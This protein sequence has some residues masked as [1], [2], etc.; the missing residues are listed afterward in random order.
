MHR[1]TGRVALAGVDLEIAP[2]ELFGLL[3]PN[4]GGKTTL[5]R[6]LTTSLSVQEGRAQVFGHDV[7]ASPHA[8]RREMGVVFQSP[9]L[10]KKLS[11]A[12]NLRYH[13]R[14]Y[15]MAGAAIHSGSSE[16]LAQFGLADRS[17][18]RVEKLSGGLARRV[19]IAKALLHRPRLLILDEPTTGLDPLARR[20]I[21]RLLRSLA[22]VGT[23][24]LL[25]THLMEEA[26]R[27][28]RIGILDCGRLVALDAPDAL[29]RAVGGDVV[30][31]RTLE[32]EELARTIRETW[33]VD[34][35]VA[36]GTVRCEHPD[37]YSLVS[38][39]AELGRQKISAVSVARPTLEDVFFDLTGHSFDENRG[40]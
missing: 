3:G 12:E 31:V 1:Y 39:L 26:E 37:G 9:S 15:G 22:D 23:T 21:W 4:G 14:L 27:C 33:H 29:R 30:T 11:V 38:R 25:T 32:P 40:Q 8:V 36:D 19:E 35:K 28:D 13:G 34:A 2:G 16:L 20:E 24:V 18:E 10:D 7:A 17:G 6:L 5:F